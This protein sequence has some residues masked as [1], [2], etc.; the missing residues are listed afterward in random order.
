MRVLSVVVALLCVAGAA[1]AQQPSGE[2]NGDLAGVM[3]GILFPNSNLIFDAQTNDP[4]APP[5]AAGGNSV[6]A[7]FSGIYTGWEVVQN[8]AIALAEAANL[9]M[10]PGRL[11]ENGRPVPVER[12]D[13]KEYAQGLEE[14]GRKA[15]QAALVEDQDQVI[16]VTNDVAGACENCHIVFRD[17]PGD[18][19][20]CVP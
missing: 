9:I 8:A 16:E 20:R 13:W 5:E 10:M 7:T 12:A 14:A 2:P 11:C 3:R 6:T 18:S 4:G 17:K 1:V 15:Y 19:P